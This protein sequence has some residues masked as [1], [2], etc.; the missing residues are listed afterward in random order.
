MTW[1]PDGKTIVLGT[2]H[3][4]VSWIDVAAG[5]IVKEE[6][7]KKEVRSFALSWSR[8]PYSRALML[9]ERIHL[10]ACRYIATDSFG[11]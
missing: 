11:F 2:R 4:V 10:L 8:F 3:D 5:K 9:D 1:S 6:K 7:N